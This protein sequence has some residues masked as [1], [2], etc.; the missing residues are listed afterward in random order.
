[1]FRLGYTNGQANLKE[2]ILK[3]E[4]FYLH[5]QYTFWRIINNHFRFY[6]LAGGGYWQ[7]KFQFT[8]YPS[9][10]DYFPEESQKGFGYYVGG[11]LEYNLSGFYLGV[12][13]SF[14]GTEEATFGPEPKDG[15]FTNQYNLFVGSNKVEVN[16]G[17]RFKF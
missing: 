12:Q 9:L 7:S 2:Y 6:A 11:G 17:Y 4:I 5:V 15:E 1:M 16:F 10:T 3:N 14:F 8:K 13:Y